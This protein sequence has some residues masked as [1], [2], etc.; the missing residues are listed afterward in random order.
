MRSRWKY[1]I[2]S[3]VMVVSVMQAQEDDDVVIIEEEDDEKTELTDKSSWEQFLFI[4]V[5]HYNISSSELGRSISVANV[6]WELKNDTWQFLALVTDWNQRTKLTQQLNFRRPNDDPADFPNRRTLNIKQ[7]DTQLDELYAIWSP[8]PSIKIAAGRRKIVWGQFDI[9]SPVDLQLPLRSQTTSPYFNKV[10]FRIPQDSIQVSW[11]PVEWLEL[12]AYHM[13]GTR[14][15]PLIE[16]IAAD[17]E[18]FNRQQLE[19]YNQ[20]AARILFYPRW[21]IVGVTYYSGRQAFGVTLLN[22][23]RNA[24]DVNRN[25]NNQVIEVNST[26][27]SDVVPLTAYGVEMSIP[28]GNWTWTF[29]LSYRQNTGEL[30]NVE[31]EDERG[32]GLRLISQEYLTWVVDHNRGRF[33]TDV[34][35]YF[36]GLGIQYKTGRWRVDFALMAI[37][38]Q[39]TGDA[40]PPANYDR[41]TEDGATISAAAPVFNMVYSFGERRNK[42]FAFSFGF[43]GSYGTGA[44]LNFIY[45][46]DHF[47]ANKAGNF[48][49]TIGADLVQYEANF[50]LSALNDEG[51]Q[52]SIDDNFNVNPRLGIIWKY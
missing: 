18:G 11:S 51:G 49:L 28:A 43:L 41:L 52:Y 5:G 22:E 8:I 14:I 20:E 25:A 2:V 27:R 32:D 45:D 35:V 50:A 9:L 47:E 38:E 13:Q 34:D 24:A 48:L 31:R 19:N 40:S 21:G 46:I 7:H 4:D 29:E 30:E 39:F 6:G 23:V 12:Q 15:D 26:E 1:I 17:G 42:H 33:Y 44:V 3:A 10:N 36:G 16:T 37:N